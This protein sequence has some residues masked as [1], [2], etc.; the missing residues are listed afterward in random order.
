MT[1]Y[2]LSVSIKEQIDAFL[3]GFYECDCIMNVR[4]LTWQNYSTAL[5]ADFPT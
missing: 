4:T 3:T 1:S 2:K 5:G